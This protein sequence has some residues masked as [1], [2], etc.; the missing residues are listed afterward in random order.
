V[1]LRGQSTVELAF[2]FPVIALLLVGSCDFG[3]LFFT[4]MELIGA[5]RAGAAYGAQNHVTAADN[6]TMQTKATGSAPDVRNVTA[7]ARS[8]CTCTNGGGSVTCTSPGACTQVQVFVQVDTYATFN[9]LLSYPGVPSSIP[10]HATAILP[11]Y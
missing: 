3:R 9:T 10:L 7:T 11:V 8:F 6:A 2:L 4:R 1:G 5:A